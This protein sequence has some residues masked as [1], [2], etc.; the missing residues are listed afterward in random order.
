MRHQILKLGFYLLNLIVF[1]QFDSFGEA[2]SVINILCPSNLSSAA[3]GQLLGS[4]LRFKHKH[5]R[6]PLLSLGTDR[7]GANFL[8]R[9]GLV[10][11]SDEL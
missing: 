9:I 11:G 3:K 7:I 2:F 6:Y 10:I 5:K 1:A 8:V 4:E